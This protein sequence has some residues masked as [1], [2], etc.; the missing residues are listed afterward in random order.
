M[1]E[2]Y[3]YRKSIKELEKQAKLIKRQRQM[4]N[5]TTARKIGIIFYLSSTKEFDAMLEFKGML[6]QK[7]LWVE[8]MG[9]FPDKEIPQFY[10]LQ[11]G[12]SIISKN[13]INWYGKPLS[14]ISNDF[15]KKDFDILID[16][17]QDEIVPLR[18]LATL[19]KAKFKVGALNYFNNPFDLMVTTNKSEG[20]PYLTSQ[21]FKTLEV[22]NNRFAEQEL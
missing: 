16:I 15:V 8:A 17:S 19:S 14:L 6:Q 9:Y 5:L 4:H 20:L 1:F 22:F 13:D 12:V 21:I 11:P 18:W 7:N 10:T 2:N 3:K